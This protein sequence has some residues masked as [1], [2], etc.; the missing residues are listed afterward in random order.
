MFSATFLSDAILDV[1]MWERNPLINGDSALQKFGMT[2]RIG[3]RDID[4]DWLVRFNSALLRNPPYTSTLTSRLH[5]N[6]TTEPITST[7]FLS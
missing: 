6:M 3:G 7:Q 5:L 4:S 2:L 1:I